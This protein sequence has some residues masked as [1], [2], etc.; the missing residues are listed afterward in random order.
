MGTE[1]L[2]SFLCKVRLIIGFYALNL[3]Y[4]IFIIPTVKSIP[5]LIFM[6]CRGANVVSLSGLPSAKFDEISDHIL[7]PLKIH[8]V[9]H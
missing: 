8:V 3:L 4:S 7:L 9:L 1:E 5:L 2:K 6:M